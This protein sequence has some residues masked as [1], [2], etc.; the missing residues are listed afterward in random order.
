[1]RVAT[2]MAVTHRSGRDLYSFLD[3]LGPVAL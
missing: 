1:M 3:G 2:E